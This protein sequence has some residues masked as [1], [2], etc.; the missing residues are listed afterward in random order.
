MLA[1]AEFVEVHHLE[2]VIDLQLIFVLVALHEGSRVA[3][4]YRMIHCCYKCLLW[5]VYYLISLPALA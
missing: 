5:S 1:L 2:L 3:L 4:Q